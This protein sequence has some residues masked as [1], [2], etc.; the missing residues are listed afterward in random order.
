MG[1]DSIY[2]E[3]IKEFC[4]KIAEFM[5]GIDFD[6]FSKDEKL[7]WAIVKLVENIGEAAKRLSD[8]TQAGF[9][10]VDWYKVTAMRNRLVHDYMNIDLSIV[11][12][13][14]IHEVP[15]LLTDLKK[16]Q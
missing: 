2:I 3:E 1:K 14:A 13:V 15:K 9:P 5:D 4:R 11:F 8:G 10:A 12:D 16:S 6:A 7:Q